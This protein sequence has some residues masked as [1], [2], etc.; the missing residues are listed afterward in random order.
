MPK[1]TMPLD[2]ASVKLCLG[3]RGAFLAEADA[4]TAPSGVA[5]GVFEQ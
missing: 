3:F 2:S 4:L 5:H 1:W